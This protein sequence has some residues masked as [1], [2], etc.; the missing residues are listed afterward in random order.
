M[1]W[2]SRMM[3]CS[4]SQPGVQSLVRHY[5]ANR[6]SICKISRTKYCRLYKVLM[7]YPDGSTITFR[8][9][10]PQ[11]IVQLPALLED[12]K[13]EADRRLWLS[14]RKRVETLRTEDEIEL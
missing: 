8:H 5:S 1:Q 7:V 10:E 12:C 6:S 13:T 2:L 14:R 4:G 3:W 9:P 11:S